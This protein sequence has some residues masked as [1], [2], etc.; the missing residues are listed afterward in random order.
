MAPTRHKQPLGT[1]SVSLTTAARHQ[2]GLL[3]TVGGHQKVPRP[4]LAVEG[5][6]L[7]FRCVCLA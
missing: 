1:A 3:T 5:S 7:I 4:L 6:P 2:V